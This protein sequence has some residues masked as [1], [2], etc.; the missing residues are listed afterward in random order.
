MSEAGSSAS[1]ELSGAIVR[2]EPKSLRRRMVAAVAILVAVVLVATS[3]VLVV[4]S[5]NYLRAEIEQRARSYAALAAAPL[6]EAYA[7]YFESGFSKFRERVVDLAELNPDLRDLAIY[8]TEGGLLFHSV[9]LDS[10]ARSAEPPPVTVADRGRLVRAVE[11]LELDAW[12]ELDP[13]GRERYL[14]VAPYLE[15]WGGHR[16]SAV[17]FVS[18]DGLAAAERNTAWQI[19]ALAVLGLG[20]GVICALFLARQILRPLK[21]L[22]RGARRLARGEWRG[23]IGLET[24]DEFQVLSETLDRMAERLASTI[25]DLEGSNRRLARMNEELQELDRIKS[26]LLANVSHELRTPLTA[27][28]G[29]AEAMDEGLLGELEEAQSHSISVMRR[30]V[31]RLHGMIEQLLSFSRMEQGRLGVELGTLELAAVA[32]GVVESLRA[33]HGGERELVFACPAELPPV[34]GD[35]EALAQVLENLLTNAIKF[36]PPSEPVTLRIEPESEGVEV[37]VVDRGLGIPPEKQGRIFE[38]FY[39]VDA[40]SRRRFGGMGLGLAIVE[41]LL[42]LQGSSIELESRP[43]EGST[44]RFVLPYAEGDDVSAGD[45]VFGSERSRGAS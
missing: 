8:D 3:A 43:G 27:I 38:R 30:N 5:R 32:R 12:A 13:L 4:Y 45:D 17:F 21:H 44:F 34:L 33:I 37:A 18:Y 36:S 39:Q 42:E 6:C 40:S 15:P 1:L 28:S 41:E 22:T 23:R 35:P 31:R 16:Y 25:E 11:G 2:G 10:P 7:T 19:A 14:V 26:D 29:Y 20:L 9:E 24:H